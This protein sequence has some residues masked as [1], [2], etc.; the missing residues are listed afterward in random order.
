MKSQIKKFVSLF[1][2]ICVAL[3]VMAVAPL[4]AETEATLSFTE[5]AN[6]TS[7]STSQQIWEQNGIKLTNDK[8][9]GNNIR[10]NLN[11]NHIRCYKGSKVTIEYPGMTKIVI[12]AT[13]SYSSGWAT[14]S[15]S[16]AT[17]TTSGTTITI[18]FATPVDS[19]V[20]ASLSAQVRATLITV[21]TGDAGT[22]EVPE[23]E[24]KTIAEVLAMEDGPT[25]FYL[26][27]EIADTYRDTWAT[28]GNFIL[29]DDSTDTTIILYGLNDENGNRYDAMA[30]QPVVGDTIKVLANR[31]SY[32]GVG[33]L[34]NAILV[35]HTPGE[36]SGGEEGGEVVV[37]STPAEIV[38]AAY[39]LA[40]GAKITGVT[41]TGKVTEIVE[42]F[43]SQY[44][45]ITVKFVIEGKEDKPLN[46]KRMVVTD[47]T[48]VEVGDTIT[49]E[50]DI[51]NNVYNS[52]STIQFYKPTLKEVVKGVKPL[53]P[54]ENPSLALGDTTANSITV[55]WNAVEGVNSYFVQ[56][57][58]KATGA[59]VK[60]VHVTDANEVTIYGLAA[61]TQYAISICS[62]IPGRPVAYAEA[63]DAS[64]AAEP[65]FANPTPVIGAATATTIDVSWNA[66]DGAKDYFVQVAD[67]ATGAIVRVVNVVDATSTTIYGLAAETQY[68]ISI[69]AHKV[70]V[71]ATYS[72]AV[73]AATTA[74]AALALGVT[75]EGKEATFTW[76]K[77]AN[78]VAYYLYVLKNG[79]VVRVAGVTDADAT[80][81]VL[82]VPESEGC[83]Y[84]IIAATQA[85]ASVAYSPMQFAD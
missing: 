21:Y 19:F 28:Y 15:D 23:P 25:Q 45:N 85:G 73:D 50:G 26:T 41:L 67:K 35:E 82:W 48:T 70:G 69:C 31:S 71:V 52:V 78:A 14:V 8:G 61:E 44:G 13:S 4:A 63:I 81:F 34:A 3:S 46:C 79:E 12:N 49:V 10:D 60:I 5:D 53:P 68:A 54:V 30:T 18:T 11:D 65:V 55:D 1:A 66:V 2:C 72:D 16:N 32:N 17:A 24:N 36:P 64:T 43:N 59:I 27:A 33:Q 22:E 83:T 56:V 9:T 7:Y 29:K 58:D 47:A 6:R 75:V 51:E 57:A 77:P 20:F 74:E 37:P 80:S 39:N 76:T 62:H 38:D 84:G 40:A 42:E